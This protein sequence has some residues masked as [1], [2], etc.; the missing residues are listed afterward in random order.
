MRTILADGEPSVRRALRVLLTQDLDMQAV[1]EV[2]RADALPRRV[3]EVQ[4]ELLVVDWEL[5]AD[6]A[7]SAFAGLRCLSPN[8]H[9]VVLGLRP[10]ARVAALTAGADG[11][12]SKLDSP[13]ETVRA[14]RAFAQGASVAE[15]GHP[16]MLTGDPTSQVDVP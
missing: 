13:E 12:A 8:L 6:E 5:V 2:S 9:I 11:F 3:G 14:L 7:A 15:P 4:P 10:E 1:C 16:S